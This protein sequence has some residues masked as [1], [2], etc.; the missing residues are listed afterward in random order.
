MKFMRFG[1]D[2]LAE[3]VAEVV[4]QRDELQAECAG[5]QKKIDT[6]IGNWQTTLAYYEKQVA[7]A[8]KEKANLQARL[9][10]ALTTGRPPTLADYGYAFYPAPGTFFQ[11]RMQDMLKMAQDAAAVP[12][13]TD[14]AKIMRLNAKITELSRLL[15]EAEARRPVFPG[16][17][18]LTD[19]EL[20]T[21]RTALRTPP[22]D[23]RIGPKD[24]R[25]ISEYDARSLLSERDQANMEFLQGTRDRVVALEKRVTG[26][27]QGFLSQLAKQKESFNECQKAQNALIHDNGMD[28]LAVAKRL[29]ALETAA[30][31]P[32][33]VGPF[34]ADEVLGRIAALEE[35]MAGHQYDREKNEITRNVT[36]QLLKH[37]GLETEETPASERRLKI[38]PK[39]NGA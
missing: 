23:V 22:A 4:K 30:A 39:R 11:D 36:A 27:L 5:L 8:N 18:S 38:V 37:L 13:E 34:P 29:H 20:S 6:M 25:L 17:A 2:M 3:D 10:R 14:N 9:D 1:K 19:H 33:S 28:F 35:F 32:A 21:L 24:G 26:E 12:L 31:A 16:N 7:D 15:S